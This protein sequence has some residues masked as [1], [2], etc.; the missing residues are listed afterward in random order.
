MAETA[1]SRSRVDRPR[2]SPHRSWGWAPLAGCALLS[3]A[4]VLAGD[5]P[6]WRGPDRD[7]ISKETGLLKEWPKD[8]PKLLWETDGVGDGY[9]TPSVAGDR[10]YLLSNQGLDDERVQA[11][12]TSD[13][14]EIWTA[15]IGKV[16]NPNQ[17]PKYPAARSTPTVVGE[18]LFVLGSDGD[19][20]CLSTAKGE[21]R[22]RKSLR[23]DFGGQP[24]KWAY[25]ESP[26]V[27]GDKLV[28]T[29]GGPDATLVALN[30]QSGE[31][32]WK[33]PVPG[34]DAAGY[35]SVIPTEAGGVRQYV[36]F[37]AQ[38][39][40][41]VEAKSG[42]YLWRYE[43]TA[44]GSPAN[45]PTPVV[46]DGL[47]YSGAG[48]SGGA[49]VRLKMEGDKFTAE[50][51]YFSAKLPTA[52]GGAVR[53][54]DHIYGCSGQ[55]LVCALF[56]SGNILWSERS[57]APGSICWAEGRLYLHGENGDVALVEATPEAYREKGRFTPTHLPQHGQ[58]KAWAYPV[59]AGGRLYIRDLGKLWCYDVQA[60]PAGK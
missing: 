56:E 44:Q 55:A 20:A 19:L 43:K 8:G 2:S 46:H 45:I 32:I 12:S 14:K 60:T 57:I 47:V 1:E 22:W 37:L 51:V 49:L 17:Q 30:K 16:G 9:S 18:D 21:V 29:P 25:S 52:I 23:A 31:V 50:Q 15:R 39:V 4:P 3:T 36:Q 10:L 5:W 6:Q 53:V 35:A 38:G 7:G 11:R 26:L 27:E 54:G 48:R 28:C 24:G 59:L 40:V 58:S 33:S 13:G 42:K 34:G 41:G